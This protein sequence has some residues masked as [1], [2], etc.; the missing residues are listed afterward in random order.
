MLFCHGKEPG[1]PLVVVLLAQCGLGALG[2]F[3][4][5]FQPGGKGVLLGVDGGGDVCPEPTGFVGQLLFGGR[6]DFGRGEERR[7]VDEQLFILWVGGQVEVYSFV[8]GAGDLGEQVCRGDVLD[9]SDAVVVRIVSEHGSRDTMLGFTEPSVLE[10]LQD[11]LYLGARTGDVAG[12]S[13][14]DR[15]GPAQE[16][17]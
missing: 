12:I 10:V 5:V 2:L 14:G 9:T 15:E 4:L 7:D 16:T 13:D 11:S 3:E 8:P 1:G 6:G 17:A